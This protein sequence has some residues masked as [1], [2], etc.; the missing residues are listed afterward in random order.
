M[1][2]QLQT[3][4][5]NNKLPARQCLI[6]V[7]KHAGTPRMCSFHSNLDFCLCFLTFSPLVLKP[8]LGRRQESVEMYIKVTSFLDLPSSCETF[9]TLSLR[10]LLTTC[11]CCRA[12]AISTLSYKIYPLLCVDHIHSGENSGL[13]F[14]VELPFSSLVLVLH[15]PGRHV[16]KLRLSYDFV[17]S[18]TRII[19][20]GLRPSETKTTRRHIKPHSAPMANWRANMVV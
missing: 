10:L 2:I 20:L 1:R 16:S 7:S 14:G 18:L 6:F 11:P 12:F 5:T 9:H 4:P 17:A 15:F 3:L 19:A 8:N 13:R